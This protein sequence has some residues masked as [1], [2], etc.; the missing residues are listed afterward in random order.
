MRRQHCG[1]LFGNAVAHP[2]FRMTDYF[3]NAFFHKRISKAFIASQGRPLGKI[4]A[5]VK[6]VDLREVA[7]QDGFLVGSCRR[8][9]QDYPRFPK[10]A[11]SP[12][13]AVLLIGRQ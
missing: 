6:C 2:I 4:V 3:S 13:R 7:A 11:N 9:L 1:E 10:V 5:N 8:M 12:V